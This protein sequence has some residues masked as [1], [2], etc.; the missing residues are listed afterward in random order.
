M[1]LELGANIRRNGYILIDAQP[2][3]DYQ[4]VVPP[5]PDEVSAMRFEMVE[6]YHFWEHLYLWQAEALAREVF[7]VL[8]PG[9]LFV[10]ELPNLARCA[11]MLLDPESVP[12]KSDAPAVPDPRFT[13]WGIYGAQ[14]DQKHIGNTHQAHKWG[15]TPESLTAQ[16][17]AAGFK[18]VQEEPV[19]R[20]QVE[21]D[22]RLVA[23]K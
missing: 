11:A 10:L 12:K 22:M 20:G 23:V 5:L 8:E 6:A 15:Y 4:G 3:G 19:T 21:R 9:G 7:A 1:R 2:G 14:S 18:S 16:L 13:V 17:K